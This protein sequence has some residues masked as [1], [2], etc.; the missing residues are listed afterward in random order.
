MP[1]YEIVT[2]NVDGGFAYEIECG[3]VVI[4]RQPHDPEL[5]GQQPMTIERALEAAQA[6]I[7]FR[8]SLETAE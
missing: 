2:F 7:D 3:G 8:K 6:E 5:A 4:Y 1:D